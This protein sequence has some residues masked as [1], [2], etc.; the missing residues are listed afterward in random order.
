MAGQCKNSSTMYIVGL[1]EGIVTILFAAALVIAYYRG[2]REMNGWLISGA[3]VLTVFWCFGF[4]YFDWSVAKVV[5]VLSAAIQEKRALV[6]SKGVDC[7]L[8]PDMPVCV[9]IASVSS[10]G[11]QMLLVIFLFVL[12]LYAVLTMWMGTVEHHWASN[13]EP[14]GES[15]L[16]A[17]KISLGR[18]RDTPLTG[19]GG[20][21]VVIHMVISVFFLAFVLVVFTGALVALY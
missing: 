3:V 2:R 6:I 21:F 17:A 4:I 8:H 5:A 10:A 7:L 16:Q 15:V 1:I 12:A 20:W 19:A 9:K 18:D 14:L 13:G 11:L